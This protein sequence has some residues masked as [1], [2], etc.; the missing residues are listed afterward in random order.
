MSDKSKSDLLVDFEC[1]P[2]DAF[3]RQDVVAAIRDCSRATVERDRWAGGGVPFVKINKQVRYRK[4]DI[5]E[6]LNKQ[7]QHHNTVF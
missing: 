4:R 2:M 6:W 3:F 5:L 7:V 1:A